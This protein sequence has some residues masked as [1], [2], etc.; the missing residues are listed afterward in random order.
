M[1]KSSLIIR[2]FNNIQLYY[3]SSLISPSIVIWKGDGPVLVTVAGGALPRLPLSQ[4]Y[5][6]IANHLVT[7]SQLCTT[8]LHKFL[9]PLHRCFP[10][11]IA[12]TVSQLQMY[13]K[14]PVVSEETDSLLHLPMIDVDSEITACS[15]SEFKLTTSKKKKRYP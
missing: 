7:V 11:G 12:N 2:I 10:S 1:Q 4:R 13:W 14:P 8:F 3:Y 15:T 9:L 6:F 5:C